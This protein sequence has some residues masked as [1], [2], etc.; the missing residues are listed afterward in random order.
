MLYYN[1]RF[2]KSPG[3][4]GEA[5]KN[6]GRERNEI[7]SALLFFVFILYNNST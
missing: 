2:G 7:A 6:T 4:Y 3:G 1:R 5:R